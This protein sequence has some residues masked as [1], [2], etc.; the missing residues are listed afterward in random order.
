MDLQRLA[1]LYLHIQM[2][3]SWNSKQKRMESLSLSF[4]DLE[5]LEVE[6]LARTLLNNYN[7]S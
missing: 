4:E 1:L 7:R 5:L 3:V 6:Q 2:A